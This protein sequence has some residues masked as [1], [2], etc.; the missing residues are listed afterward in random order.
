MSIRILIL[1]FLISCIQ[2]PLNN[3]RAQSQPIFKKIN[4]ADGLSNGRVTS[5]VREANGFVW[6]G[7]KNGLNRYDGL[8]M[9]VYNKQN[10]NISSND[11]SDV[12]IDSKGRMWVSTLG[13]GLNR[14]DKIHDKFIVY[15]NAPGNAQSISSN[16]INTIFEDSQGH[17]WL[18]TENGLCLI[19]DGH[20]KSFHHKSGDN[21][22]I[23][24]NSVM[25][26]YEDAEGNLWI[27]TFGGGLNKFDPDTERFD[28]IKPDNILLSDYI[29]IIA[30]FD[31]Q[32]LL[33]GTSGSGLLVFNRDNQQFSSFFSG[34]L[35][36]R[37]EVNIVRS[38]ARDSLGNIWIGTDG[39]G[40][41]KIQD[42]SMEQPVIY[43][44]MYNAQLPTSISGNAIYDIIEDAEGNIWIGTAWN[45]IN[46]LSRG[47]NFEFI[48]SDIV[49]EDP[50]PV[51]SVYKGKDKLFL[52]LDGKGLT[53]Y[54]PS[55]EE[56]SYYN[57]TANTS[58]G[59][60]YIQY[61]R[62]SQ[63]GT[64][65][66]GTF[67]NGLIHFDAT[68][69]GFHQY[70]YEPKNAQSLSYN[71]VRYILE[72]DNGN[73]WIA[74]WGGG[75]NYF[76]KKTQKFTSF[77]EAESNEGGIS[78]D[79]VI[80][81]QQDKS[82]LWIATFGGG[83]NRLDLSTRKF[84][85]YEYSES[86]STSL[87]SNNIFSIYKD[88]RGYLW[89]GTSGE[90]INRY[91]PQTKGFE[92]FAT[93]QNIRYSTV[94]AIIEDDDGTIWFSTKQG[95]FNYDYDANDFNSFPN[96]S[97][98]FHINSV[99]KD[100]KGLLYFGG[101]NGVLRFD[102]NTISYEMKPPTVVFTNFKLFNKDLP[103]GEKEILN[104]SIAFQ[105]KMTLAHD[106]DVITFEFA[107]LQFPF[108][109]NCEYAIKMENFDEDWRTIGKDRTATFT[110][111]S[112]GNY[113]F[114]VKSRQEGS[115]W[116]EHYASV[117]LEILKPFWMRWWAFVIYCLLIIGLF[118]LF[119]KYTIAW[120]RMKANLK[121]EKLTHEKDTELYNLK[122][123]FFTNISHEI[124]TPVTLILS[125][126]NRL[127]TLS[128][129]LQK[130]QQKSFAIIKKNGNHL[131]QLVNELLDFKKFES[132]EIKL[133]VSQDNWVAFCEEIYLSFTE[134]ALQKRIEFNFNASSDHISLWFDKSQMEKVV[135]NLLS[136]AFKFT[137]E[138]G[139]ITMK[140]AEE[141][142][143]VLLTVR[144][145]GIGVPKKKLAKI[146]N[147]F[148]Q[149]DNAEFIKTSGFG[150]GLSIS[151]EIIE[152][153]HGEITVES[154]K[155][156]GST[157]VIG[158]LQGTD[159]FSKADLKDEGD[160]AERIENYF[161]KSDDDA[162]ESETTSSGIGNNTILIV[163][164][165]EDIRNYLAEVLQS[166][167]ELLE[168][169]NGSEALKIATENI[170]D[171]IISD[172][173]MPVM[174]GISLTRKLKSD[175]RT[176]HI[177][178]ILLT[179]RA[180]F[181]HKREGFDTGADD[182]ITK[183]FNEALLRSRIKNLLRT[184]ALLR[185]KFRTESILSPQEIA[186]NQTDRGFLE[187][188]IKAI[189]DNID[190][191]TLNAKFISKE[192]GMSHSVIYKKTKAITGMTFVEF[193]RD[194]KLSMARKLIAQDNF[195]VAEA[196]Y[197]VG[198]ADKK[199]FSKLFKGKFGKNPSEFSSTR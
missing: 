189:R 127:L 40:I 21:T 47:N 168:A 31:E 182:Y 27:G 159:H 57:K 11:I 158:L 45:G 2:S 167:G 177:P 156:R 122:Q 56:V 78:S 148:Y 115:E 79:N 174:D 64:Y 8:E 51:L 69:G 52:G 137:G 131:L 66:L 128:P 32:S 43:N 41:F 178:I 113:K 73:L 181:I 9:R 199:Y 13:G 107:A 1:T 36:I 198:Y 139:A 34:K 15:K 80:S 38:L 183:P 12:F 84:T 130:S 118:Y 33:I 92:R 162:D 186:S 59:G 6:V 35:E 165:N 187:K 112:P 86:D 119:R 196:C 171:L 161:L 124:R 85:H 141:N 136:N 103:I 94:T 125:S 68:T 163:E 23:S 49:G 116:G 146:F 145:T 129:D 91:N 75:L 63:L 67:A 90:G 133:N 197:K 60:Q 170:P 143:R 132:N 111:L 194:F 30:K 96:L 120:E 97:G 77:R 87:A 95:I 5:I 29:H 25:S 48:F 153:H 123:Q 166:D 28:N 46:I 184:R 42:G 98:E 89:V 173:M 164:D 72:D 179:A 135:Y 154:E 126:V 26:I 100:Q 188:L 195:S 140:V 121:L 54:K 192:L 155:N 4:Q 70:K 99:F 53:V 138:G 22:S 114:E 37:Q 10:S 104:K 50:T 134:I 81:L 169:T 105:D 172:I 88:S 110:N 193:V 65:W 74:T 149:S 62:E 19:L 150:L 157:F 18:G 109:V 20:F 61:I 142:K 151:K 83:I 71:D 16:H 117:D 101:I 44:Y 185:E 175:V 102:P 160:N 180:S 14:Y 7:T 55:G 191:E 17:I 58:I 76:D 147:R 176:S 190:S 106:L 144:D 82:T 39:N 93:E 152:L 108:S 3:I 24:H